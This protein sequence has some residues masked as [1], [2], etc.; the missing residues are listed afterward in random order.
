[1]RIALGAKA[2]VAKGFTILL[3]LFAPEATVSEFTFAISSHT[4]VWDDVP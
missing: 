3:F 2:V 1:M 4:G